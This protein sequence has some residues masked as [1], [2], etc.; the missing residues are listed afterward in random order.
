MALTLASDYI[1]QAIRKCGAM[2]AGYTPQTELLTDGLTEWG[3][4]YDSFAAER[5]MG[6]SVP[7]YTYAVNGPGSQSSGNGY[8]IGPTAHAVGNAND[9]Q[10]PRPT[11]IVRMNC[12]LNF[13]SSTP[14][15]V[16][17]LS[18]SAEE[19]ASLSIRQIPAIN[20][21]NLFYY[22]PQYS[23]AAGAPG[24]NGVLNIFPPQTG[25]G[26]ELFCSQAW[27][28]PATLATTYSAPPGYQDV[29]VLGLAVRMWPLVDRTL[30]PNKLSFEYLNGKFYEACQKVRALN[31]PIP[32]LPNT[33]PGRKPAGYY[34]SFVS[35]TGEPY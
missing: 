1:K 32:Q 28:V 6:W 2:R 20:V 15:Y 10:G 19:W 26:V 16:P 9:F 35:S 33:F 17:M 18:I 13:G 30:M 21:S 31:R 24:P 27:A 34:D 29:I 5:T 12:I 14:V 22:D 8:L 23:S 3:S 25:N 11:M 4:M 7:D